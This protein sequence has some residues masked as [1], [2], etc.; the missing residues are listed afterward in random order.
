MSMLSSLCKRSSCPL[1]HGEQT[2][3]TNDL[4][5]CVPA[6]ILEEST[7]EAVNLLVGDCTLTVVVPA[8]LS[9]QIPAGAV[10]PR[11]ASP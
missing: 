5:V 10:P 1:E 3:P 6:Q 2:P 8:W 9:A 4:F 11:S 7:D